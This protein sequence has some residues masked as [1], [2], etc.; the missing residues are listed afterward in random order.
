[1]RLSR[2]VVHEFG[3][4]DVRPP[5]L[6]DVCEEESKSEATLPSPLHRTSDPS[7]PAD[8]VDVTAS[9]DMDM[10]PTGQRASE[11]SVMFCPAAIWAPA[12]RG[13]LEGSLTHVQLMDV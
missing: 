1:M 4:S 13:G 10:D 2:S 11:A 7:R 12:S 9:M 6:R 8:S 3:Q 5:R